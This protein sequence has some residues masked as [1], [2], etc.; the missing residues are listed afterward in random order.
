M[1]EKTLEDRIEIGENEYMD[2]MTNQ[3]QIHYTNYERICEGLAEVQCKIHRGYIVKFYTDGKHIWYESHP[4]NPVGF[5]P[6]EEDV[7]G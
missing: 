4:K 1:T 6:N 5:R 7:R 2:I 3:A